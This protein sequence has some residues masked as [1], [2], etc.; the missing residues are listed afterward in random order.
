MFLGIVGDIEV[1]LK[2]PCALG[3][4][5]IV[6]VA[7]METLQGSTWRGTVQTEILHDLRNQNVGIMVVSFVYR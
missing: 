5:E 3:L 2:D 6:A 4:P 7:H 1:F